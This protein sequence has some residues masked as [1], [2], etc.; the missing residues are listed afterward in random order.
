MAT[1]DT[2]YT[3]ATI[4]TLDPANPLAEAVLV[5]GGRVLTVGAL[6]DLRGQ[7]GGTAREVDLAGATMLPGFIESHNHFM[8]SG[9]A[10]AQVDVRGH[11]C[12][13][14]G[15]LQRLLDERA[16][17]TSAGEWVIGRG[18]D[19]TLLTED[20]HPT[21]YDLDQAV[22]EHPAVIFHISY[23]ALVANSAALRLAGLDRNTA[24]ILGGEILRDE[25]GEP[26]GVLTE[27]AMGLV[28]GLIPRASMDDLRDGVRLAR[29]EFLPTGVAAVHD[30]LVT[31]RQEIDAYAA[32]IAAGEL[33]IRVNL[34]IAPELYDGELEGQA[35]DLGPSYGLPP[36]RLVAGPVKLLH[37][38]AIQAYTAALTEPYFDAPDRYGVKIYEPEELSR[39]VAQHHSMGRQIAIHG[40]GDAAI[41][42]ILDAYEVALATHP[43]A[44][45]RHRIE[46]CQTARPDQLERMAHLGVVASVFINHLWYFGD[47]HLSRFLGPERA[48]RMEPLA[49]M[50]RLGITWGLHCDSPVTEVN[51]LLG[52]WLAV[53]RRTS[54]GQEI[55]LDERVPVER[56][57][58]GFG[59]DAAYLGFQERQQGTI[60][61][62]YLAD[63]TI[64]DGDPVAVPEGIKDLRVVG[65]VIDGE[66]AWDGS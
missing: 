37:D 64:L 51:P 36:N 2:L 35:G 66:M 19:Q 39:I 34:M 18:Y 16:G 41:D 47:R 52:L 31:T 65:T 46:H 53:N 8:M 9:R 1:G 54:G 63:F 57:L 38:G 49:S 20:R 3:N 32:A 43:R 45:H 27:D 5:R 58:R 13:S 62:G 6:D 61:P 50:T 4:R 25:H 11:V 42:D 48:S 30:A 44:N 22:P 23:H 17:E 60:A 40:N 12:G 33:P 15:E 21:R 56:A 14:I 10:F 26:T 59:P 7:S 29:D 24:D 28:S 55:G